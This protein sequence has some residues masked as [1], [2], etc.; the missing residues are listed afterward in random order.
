MTSYDILIGTEPKRLTLC[1]HCLAAIESRE[2]DQDAEGIP[3]GIS[4]IECDW[5]HDIICDD[6]FYE[7]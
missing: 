3:V 2:G 4:E 5:C 1:Y 7:I 6:F